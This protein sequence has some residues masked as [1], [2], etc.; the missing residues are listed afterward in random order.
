MNLR[1]GP[2]LRISGPSD[3]GMTA[4]VV[5][6]RRPGRFGE[7]RTTPPKMFTIGC[8]RS[9]VYIRNGILQWSFLTIQAGVHDDDFG[10]I[11]QDESRTYVD[12]SA[13]WNV[14]ESRW[15]FVELDQNTRVASVRL[16][17]SSAAPVDDPVARIVR[18]PLAEIGGEL[19]SYPPATPEAEPEEIFQPF[20]KAVAHDGMIKIPSSFGAPL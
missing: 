12:V 15:A 18:W 10:Q 17:G 5:E 4:E 6:R 3:Q 13:G 7:P 2:G 11:Y 9:V 1:A 16:T 8:S 20:I 14:E 19:V